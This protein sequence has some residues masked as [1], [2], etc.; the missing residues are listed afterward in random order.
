[1][2]NQCTPLFSHTHYYWYEVVILIVIAC[3]IKKVSEAVEKY[4]VY[5]VNLY[6]IISL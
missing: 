3:M 5:S 1:M 6:N 4:L 2:T